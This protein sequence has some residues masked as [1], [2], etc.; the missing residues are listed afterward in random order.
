MVGMY[1][2][3]S[4]QVSY[5]LYI[6]SD[7]LAWRV[8]DYGSGRDPPW[9]VCIHTVHSKFSVAFVFGSGVVTCRG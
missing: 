2:R 4:Y 9:I 6:Y 8:Y 7:V 5:T 1:T 3:A